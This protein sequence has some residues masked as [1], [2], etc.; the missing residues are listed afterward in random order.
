MKEISIVLAEW[1]VPGILSGKITQLR[2]PIK[3]S[4]EFEMKQAVKIDGCHEWIFWSANLEGNAKLTQKA[5]KPGDGLRSPFGQPGDLL[6]GKE[7]FEWDEIHK[8]KKDIEYKAT[9][10]VEPTEGWYSAIYMPR[11]AS[12]LTLE[13]KRVW[14]ERL[15]DMDHKDFL[16]EGMVGQ[17][18]KVSDNTTPIIYPSQEFEKTWNK[19]YGKKYPASLNPW[20]WCCEFEVIK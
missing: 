20:M 2:R 6:W 11:W 10:F 5:Y 1:E 4:S 19:T 12:R 16:A 7:T 13:V 8:N 3:L 15:S 9:S 18:W 17:G 14:V